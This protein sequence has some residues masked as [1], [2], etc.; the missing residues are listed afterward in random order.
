VQDAIKDVAGRLVKAWIA[1]D[2]AD[3]NALDEEVKKAKGLTD[4]A[5]K[6]VERAAKELE[7]QKFEATIQCIKFEGAMAK[8][9]IMKI[10]KATFEIL[11]GV[12]QLGA[13]IAAVG[14]NP[15]AAG[16]LSKLNPFNI[17]LLDQLPLATR[18]Q[19]VIPLLYML[20]VGLYGEY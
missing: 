15:A 6:A 12:V 5:K 2:S 13:A 8:D 17:P 20:P 3:L 16:A 7:A 18:L 4:E 10:V 9:R 11:Q 14:T 19:T 1:R